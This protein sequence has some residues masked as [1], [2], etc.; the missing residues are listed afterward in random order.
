MNARAML[1]SLVTGLGHIYLRHY[2]LGAALFAIFAASLNGVFLGYLLHT[3]PVLA[4][5]LVYACV[6]AAAGVWA[7]GLVHAWRISYGTDRAALR[8]ERAALFKDGLAAYLRDDLE[9]ARGLFAKAVACDVDW[10]DPDALFYLGVLDLRIAE[11]R[12]GLGERVR[13][14]RSRRRGLRAL[15]LCLSRDDSRKWRAEVAQERARARALASR[16]KV[17]A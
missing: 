10:E 13:A 11:R 8:R 17:E 4:R 2:V 5:L 12:D 3:R 16:E 9:A 15:A 6:P 14:E 1:L 7:I